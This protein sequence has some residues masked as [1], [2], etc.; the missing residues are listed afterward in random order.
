MFQQ[1]SLFAEKNDDHLTNDLTKCFYQS[2][3][4]SGF[5]YEEFDIGDITFKG[6]QNESV[7]RW[8]RLTP[9]YSPNLVRFFINRFKITKNDFVLDPFSGRGT[10]IIEC[11]K[12]GIKSLGIEINPLLQQVGSKS[13]LWDINHINLVNNYL[14]EIL[15]LITKYQEYSLEDIIKTFNTRIPIIHNVFRWWKIDVLKNLIIC[16]EVM[17]QEKYDAIHEYTWLSINKAC[18]DCANIHRNHPTI[19]FDDH[20]QRE[21][22]V[23]AEISNNL[24]NIIDD[25][26]SLNQQQISFS[27]FNSIIV[28]NS[29]NILEQ[30]IDHPIDFIIT[31]PPYPNRYSYVH[32]TRPQLHFLELLED[33]S[34]ATEIDLQAIGGTWGRATSV[35]QKNLIIVPD[36]IKPYLSYYHELK[37]QNILM[38]NY[39][40]KYFID[41]WKHIK[42]LKQMISNHFQGVYVVGNSRLS[43]VEIFTEVILGHLFQHEG[44]EVEKIISFRKRGGKKR[45]YETGVCIKNIR[46]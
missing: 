34:Q 26:L 8:Y 16:R 1:L 15:N 20:H 41:M 14:E 9:S 10:T 24:K 12:H 31:S 17:N 36:E 11:Q 40:T 27:Q 29:T 13:L 35:L 45:L 39:A 43:N 42:C 5:N 32:Q 28:G 22:D 3:A 21:I 30:K 46:N 23:Y 6:G 38:C 33:V 4:Q 44:F 19:T 37:N 7:H 18:L 25:L 2:I